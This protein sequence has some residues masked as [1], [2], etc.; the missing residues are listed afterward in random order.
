VL[1]K[2]DWLAA[3]IALRVVGAVLVALQFKNIC[4]QKMPDS[5]TLTN[6]AK[7][8]H[9]RRVADQLGKVSN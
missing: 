4:S 3:G 5:F 9:I 7:K 8:F 1:T 6:P 2:E